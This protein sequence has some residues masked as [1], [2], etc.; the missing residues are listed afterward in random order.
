[1]PVN[2][3]ENYPMTWKP[4]RRSLTSPL[5]ASLASMLEYDILNGFLAPNTKLPPQRELA[6]FLDI[7]LS[8]VTRAFKL[9]EAKG[10]IYAITGSGTFV[11]PNAGSEIFIADIDT[12]KGC[13]EMG[14]I[15]AF[16]ALNIHVAEVIR[17]IA[18]KNYLDKLLDYGYPIGAPYHR[19]AAKQWMARFNMETSLDNIAITSGGQNSFTLVL[20]SL[21]KP[22]DKIAVDAYTYPNFIELSN[23]LNIQL[24]PVGGDAMGMLPQ[25]LE[26]VCRTTN[27]KG[28]YLNPSCNNPTAVTMPMSRRE[29]LAH[30]IRD[31]GL[32]LMED[33]IYSFL[34]PSDYLPISHFVPE[35]FVY[36][37]SISKALA[38]GLR[39]AFIAYA[40]G[41][42]DAI[43]RG[44]CN[45]NIKTSALNSEIAAELINNGAAEAIITK[46]LALSRER[47]Q[48]YRQYFSIENP[49]ENPLSL[50]RWLRLPRR[51]H[52]KLLEEALMKR[53]LRLFHSYR[54][55][56]KREES[57]QFV[58][59]ALSSA[60]DVKEL[61]RGL[62]ILKDFSTEK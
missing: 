20:I 11:A 15:K 1:M 59:V 2:S 7:N 19:M 3:F 32:I 34:C 17:D 44:I 35:K 42:A 56:V 54:F 39:V 61:E 8:T 26:A 21:F 22:G 55:I 51:Y 53:G 57:T 6:D 47:N 18:E 14:L 40:R 50:Y 60:T 27:L 4:D 28:I 62:I 25:Q 33:D 37:H 31:N 43:T 36:M 46:K 58:R 23:M 45:I 52:P 30:V 48:I 9:C 41:F 16:D 38:S 12:S 5:Y 13:I 10:L 49:L 24:V 29:E